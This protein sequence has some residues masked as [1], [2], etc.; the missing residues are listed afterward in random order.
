[1][2]NVTLPQEHARQ[3]ETLLMDYQ[4]S[5]PR[6]PGQIGVSLVY[7]GKS[8]PD[9]NGNVTYCDVP[10]PALALLSK[11]GIPHQIQS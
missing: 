4:R 7:P 5:L 11:S 2:S 8:G 1:M 10:E 6:R 3:F 9:V